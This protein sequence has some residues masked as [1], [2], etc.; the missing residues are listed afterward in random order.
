M[1]LVFKC[2]NGAIQKIFYFPQN[3]FTQ[4]RNNE[5]SL[6]VL[7]FYLNIKKTSC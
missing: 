3:D 1:T 6:L 5:Y 4:T 2:I 7:K